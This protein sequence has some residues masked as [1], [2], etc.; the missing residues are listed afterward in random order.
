MPPQYLMVIDATLT[1]P[2]ATLE[3][4]YQC[5]INT[6]NV[7]TAF[8]LVEEGQ[9][10]PQPIQSCQWPVPDDDKPC[11]PAKQQQCILNN[12][13]EITLCKAMESV[14][15]KNSEEQPLTCFLYLGNANLLLKE[16]VLKYT[17][18][19]SL[20]RYFLWKHINPPWPARG[21]ECN[22]CGIELFEQKAELLNH[23][24]WCHG[25]VVQGHTQS[26][27][28]VECQQHARLMSLW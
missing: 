6:I 2:G 15:I 10:M 25:T 14:W 9:S 5:W 23:A 24:E 3:A 4:E 13:T 7:M 8:C 26:R 11:P 1:M 19:G 17:T 28:V 20:T 16:W 21:V 18:P 22:V 27:L 12:N